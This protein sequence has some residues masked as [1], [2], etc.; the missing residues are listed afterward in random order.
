MRKINLDSCCFFGGG[1][2]GSFVFFQF[3]DFLSRN[4]NGLSVTGFFGFA[5]RGLSFFFFGGLC[6]FFLDL[7]VGLFGLRTVSVFRVTIFSI[8]VLSGTIGVTV[9]GLAVLSFTVGVI[10]VLLVAI[11]FR[12]TIFLLG[13]TVC[14]FAIGSNFFLWLFYCGFLGSLL[15]DL[16]GLDSGGFLVIGHFLNVCRLK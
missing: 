7:F 12:C 5:L 9:L 10:A 2:G 13:G 1:G 14:R 6:H 8:S 3:G 11:F 15:H 16:R 4:G